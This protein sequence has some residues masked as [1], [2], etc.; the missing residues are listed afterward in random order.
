MNG[1]TIQQHP[2]PRCAI[3]RTVRI[4][5]VSFCF[6]CRLR[7]GSRWA[8]VFDTSAEPRVQLPYTFTAAETARLTIYR[9]A[10]R[11]GFY[12]DQFAPPLDGASTISSAAHSLFG[13]VVA[14]QRMGVNAATRSVIEAQR[15]EWL[16]PQRR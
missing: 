14:R 11:A 1:A 12:S 7:W 5:R 13:T 4:G 6:N 8:E 15:S 3:R 2:C 10:I 16:A 9:N